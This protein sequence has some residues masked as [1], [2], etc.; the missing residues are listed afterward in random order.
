MTEKRDVD[1]VGL[2]TPQYDAGKSLWVV[3]FGA[4][5]GPIAM[6]KTKESLDLFLKHLSDTRRRARQR[7]AQ[8]YAAQQKEFPN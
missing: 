1:L 8:L 7:R 2:P 4:E 6:G 3:D 5:G